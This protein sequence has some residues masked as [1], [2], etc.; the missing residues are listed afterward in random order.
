M[1]KRLM[2]VG[3]IFSVMFKFFGHIHSVML[4]RSNDLPSSIFFKPSL[5]LKLMI[6]LT[7]EDWSIHVDE[8]SHRK[9]SS[10]QGWVKDLADG[11][12]QHVGWIQPG[13]R[14]LNLCWVVSL[15]IGL[16]MKSSEKILISG[17]SSKIVTALQQIYKYFL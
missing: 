1:F 13:V 14:G 5:V 2:F 3:V 17:Q 12:V 7:K 16:K 10:C 8:S 9:D 15:V 11:I 4:N 6:F